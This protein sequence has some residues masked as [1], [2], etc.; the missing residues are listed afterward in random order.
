M[1]SIALKWPVLIAIGVLVFFL[2]PEYGCKSDDSA[3]KTEL[4]DRITQH[5][6]LMRKEIEKILSEEERRNE[7]LALI[8]EM[9]HAL[10]QHT[11]D[12]DDFGEEIKELYTD[13]D[14]RREVIE[15]SITAYKVK[16]RQVREQILNIHFKMMA[17]TSADEWEQILA[18][19]MGA[20]ESALKISNLQTKG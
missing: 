9:E 7:F 6:D 11:R 10:Y 2:I 4:K 16:R 18:F 8:Q 14:S 1:T 20:I 19:E 13:F 15:E 12:F 17:L 3:T 5:S